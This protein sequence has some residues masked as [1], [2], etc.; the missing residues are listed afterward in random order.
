[1]AVSCSDLFKSRPVTARQLRFAAFFPR[2]D[3]LR[4]RFLAMNASSPRPQQPRWFWI[5]SIWF[6][7]GLFDATQTV[8]SM[9]AEGMHHAWVR[10]FVTLL[11][12]WLPWALAT[13][14]LVHLA[15]LYPPVRP[16][17]PVTWLV[18][19]VA[20]S[21]VGLVCAAWTAGLDELL[22]PWKTFNPRDHSHRLCRTK[23][24]NPF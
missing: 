5:A 8:F 14:L 10:L 3:G 23:F 24:P 17:P 4:I 1:M 20:C 22:N 7:I 19:S 18:H 16:R 11:L 21:I 9:R 2:L 15:H 12:S 6:A 13:P